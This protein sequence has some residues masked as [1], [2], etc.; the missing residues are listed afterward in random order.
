M[1]PPRDVVVGVSAPGGCDTALALVEVQDSFVEPPEPGTA[2]A[3]RLPGRAYSVVA[4]QVITHLRS[5]PTY[6]DIRTPIPEHAAVGHFARSRWTDE[7]WQ[8]TDTLARALRAAAV[9]LRTPASF[10][11][12][13]Q[14]EVQLENF[15]AHAM[16]P[17]LA[18]AW[19]WSPGSWPE[20]R[21]LALAERIGVLP[22]VD[23]LDRPVPPGEVFYLRVTGGK[24]GRRSPSDDHLKKIAERVR[25]RVGWLVFANRTSE[26][27]AQRLA[28]M[29]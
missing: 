2:E 17:G 9:L 6:R 28:H 20:G 23:P 15:V 29:L 22:A 1:I 8:R 5:S 19:E 11:P 12:G 3:W 27:D 25:D 16:R 7:A 14:N 10:R 24:T 26:Q 13:S 4:W 21:A 18:I